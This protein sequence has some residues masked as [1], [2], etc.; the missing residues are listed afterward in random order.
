M[1]QMAIFMYLLRMNVKIYI[2]FNQPR[3]QDYSIFCLYVVCDVRIFVMHL[4]LLL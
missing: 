4:N 1:N 3:F 2:Y